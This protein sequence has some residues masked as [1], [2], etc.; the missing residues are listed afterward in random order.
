MTVICVTGHFTL[1]MKWA[2]VTFK[3]QKVGFYG[4]NGH[5]G[6]E[7]GKSQI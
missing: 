6:L 4:S 1:M 2:L 7:A 3:L 5:T